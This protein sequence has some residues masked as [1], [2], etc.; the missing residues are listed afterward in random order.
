MRADGSTRL[1]RV[2]PLAAL[3]LLAGW[4]G[5]RG[6]TS[7][8]AVSLHGDMP[9]YLMNGVYMLDLLRDRPFG[10]LDTFIEYTRFYFARYPALSLGHHPPLLSALEVPSFALFGVSVAA[11]R[12]VEVLSFLAAVA[13]LFLLVDELYGT[14]AAFFAGL[15]FVT[16]PMVVLLAQSVMSELPTLALI[17]WSAYFLRRFCLTER[18]SAL[19]A[20][21][22]AASLSLYAKQLAVFV[23]PAYLVMAVMALGV[24]RL[25]RRD[26]VV[27]VTLMGVAILPLVPMTLIL[28]ATNVSATVGLWEKSR[29]TVPHI[30]WA[31]LHAQIMLPVMVA[32]AAGLVLAL[33]RLDRRSVPFVV[34]IAGMAACLILAGQYEPD[35]HGLF[36]V[37][38]I[39]ALAGSVVSGWKSRAPALTAAGLLVVAGGVQLAAATHVEL[40]GAAGYE[41]AARFVLASNPGPTVLF[42][43]DVDTG[44]FT[45]FVRKHDVDRRLVVLRSDKILTTSFMGRPSIADR[46]TD[47]A[48]IYAALRR[49]GTRYVVIEERPSQSR[50]LEWLR[51]ELHGPHFKARWAEPIGT[52]DPRLRGTSLVVYEYLDACPPDPNAILSMDLPIISRSVAVKLSELTARKYLR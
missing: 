28:S 18:R 15:F 25:L 44:F 30:L 2:L 39:A 16:S 10:G 34:W 51:T 9:K 24:R 38:A 40:A 50:V 7:E 27:A 32:A 5:A 52:R 22:A 41:D 11:A 1:R 13:G 37:P 17:L 42:S 43:G 20:F 21:A 48:E 46:V 47:P 12:L 4:L 33:V 29:A 45:F 23:F 19:M 36:W 8:A 31:A 14:A 49:F 35:R 6:I 3:C 26:V